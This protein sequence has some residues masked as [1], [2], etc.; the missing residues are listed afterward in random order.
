MIKEVYGH[1]GLSA[2]VRAIEQAEAART[3]PGYAQNLTPSA[4][5]ENAT[6]Q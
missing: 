6:I 4:E 3:N 2:K 1:I 5:R